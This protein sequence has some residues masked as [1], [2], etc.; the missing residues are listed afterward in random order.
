[1]AEKKKDLGLPQT[2]GSFQVRGKVNGTKKEKF[3]TEK[4]TKTDKPKPWRAVS[5][6]VEFEPGSTMYVGLNGMEK[7]TVYFGKRPEEKGGKYITK[8]V[9]WKDRFTFAEKDFELIG[10][11]LGVTKKKDEKGNEVND[12]KKMTDYDSCKEIADNLVDNK[13]VFVKGNIE[14]GSYKDKHTTKFI[15]SQVSLAKDI[16]FVAE[17][18]KPLADF[19]QVIVYVSTTP[20]EDKTR[21][22]VAAKIVT[23]DSVQDAEFIITDMNLARMFN[24]NL[25]PYT[26][27]KVWG[28]I[29]VEENTEEVTTT[30]CWGTENNMEKANT[31]TIRELIITGA[32]PETIDTTT[33]TEAEIDKAI[34][35]AKASKA[36]EKDFG[37]STEGWGSV[38]KSNDADDDCGW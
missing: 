28:N 34:E 30:D 5:F 14:Y 17:D 16:D 1:M 9:P 35:S 4:L 12:K 19:T 38:E 20:N 31:P 23:Y 13:T 27:I 37:G 36:A 7:D 8:E 33:Y 29:S 15:P 3:Y 32:D 25:K 11:S 18:F 26:S 24:K 6:G 21:V 2:K 10:V 22:T